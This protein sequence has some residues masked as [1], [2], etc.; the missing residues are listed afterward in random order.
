M[1][2]KE[3][4]FEQFPPVSTEQWMEKITADLKGADFSK[5]LVWK[6][7]EGLEIMPFYRQDDL[8]K[9][10][11]KGFLPGDY[12][13]VRGARIS[14]NT[15]LVRQDII[16]KDYE[17]AN[18]RALEILMKGVTSLGF[19]IDDPKTINVE[20][21]THLLKDIHCESVELNFATSGMARELFLALESV[22]LTRGA[23]TAKV[24]ISIAADP[25]GRLLA[26]GKLC[27][28]VEEGLD[29]LADLV[30]EASGIPGLKCVVANGT[31]FGNAGAGPVTELAYTL[32]LGNEYMAALTS[33]GVRPDTAASAMKFSF[34]IGPDFFPEVARL[35]A[36]RML[37]AIIVE[38]YDP[39]SVKS[40]LMHIHSV[41]GRWNK[42]LYDPYVNMLRTQTEAMSAALGGADSITVEPF[43]AI[44]R[45]PDDFSER[46]ARNQQLLLME[47]SHLDKVADPGA[48]SYYIEELTSA[49]ASE[50]WKTFLQIENDGGFLAALLKGAISEKISATAAARL[51][52]ASKRREI[53]LGTNQY[54]NFMEERASVHDPARLFN[55]IADT[56]S[57]EVARV[58]PSRGAEQFEKLRL[59]VE[60]SGRRPL[61]FMLTIGNMAMRRARAQFSMN[62]FACAG[63]EVR[64]N[65]GFESAAEGVRDALDAGADIIVICSSDDEYAIIAHDIFTLV[66][67]KAI[68]VVAGNPPS[69]D[70]LKKEGIE[71][72][73]SIRSDVLETLKLF[74]RLLGIN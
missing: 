48:G 56:A 50:A 3:K 39:K 74:N 55:E 63:Y 68:V 59:A 57:D 71:H 1:N 21:I 10:R 6:T 64:D 43:D 30:K 36:A 72:F 47:E 27:V 20:N 42:T 34:G 70:L 16:V 15:W 8:D 7:R 33:R 17:A 13:W 4:L 22:M 38:K 37:W 29:Y 5:K 62:F 9:L 60:R 23:D 24:K 53:L 32:S 26:N 45:E 54:P 58:I 51:G 41:T 67:G 14:N 18:A 31:I 46:I 65:N 44:F 40:T 73:I 69:T 28:S 61:A 49:I 35:R 11:R 66:A 25:L 2:R 52:D 19:V 12:P